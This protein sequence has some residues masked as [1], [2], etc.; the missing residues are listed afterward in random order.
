LTPLISGLLVHVRGLSER[1]KR[2]HHLFFISLT[3]WS[4]RQLRRNEFLLFNNNPL[5][6]N[7][8][9]LNKRSVLYDIFSVADATAMLVKREKIDI[10]HAHGGTT[11]ALVAMLVRF[12]TGVPYTVTIHGMERF[13]ITNPNIADLM[14]AGLMDAYKIMAPSAELAQCISQNLEIPPTRFAIIPN[15]IDLEL[16]NST[17]YDCKK[18]KKS[19]GFEEEDKLILYVG[20]LSPEKHVDWLVKCMPLVLQEK[21]TCHL[22][23]VGEGPQREL[24]KT[25]TSSLKIKESVKFFGQIPHNNIPY[26]LAASDVVVEPLGV[27]YGLPSLALLEGLAMQ[28]PVV[29]NESAGILDNFLGVFT[30]DTSNPI[31]LSNVIIEALSYHKADDLE[32]NRLTLLEWYNED[33]MTKKVE[34]IYKEALKSS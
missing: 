5:K 23:I 3:L 22:L 4:L 12:L 20:R 28:K 25:F 27:S 16:F 24:L 11:Q 18:I 7:V 26:Y 14:R 19:L 31:D 21:R 13:F 30:C 10:I 32:K 1:L 17:R 15:G 29:T 6:L 34:A 33:V 2:K 8:Y 9:H